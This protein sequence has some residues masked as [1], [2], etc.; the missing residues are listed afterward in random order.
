MDLGIRN[1]LGKGLTVGTKRPSD[2]GK[3]V[4]GCGESPR[5][6]EHSRL[7][8]VDEPPPMAVYGS[9][10]KSKDGGKTEA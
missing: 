3:K 1:S 4:V 10:V 2:M 6:H 8:V 9:L 7:Y 5:K